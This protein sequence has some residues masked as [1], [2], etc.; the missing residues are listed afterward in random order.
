MEENERPSGLPENFT[1]VEALAASQK[2]AQATITRLSQELSQ[3]RGQAPQQTQQT[4]Q[5]TRQTK[6]Q[7]KKQI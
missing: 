6:K 1:S 5:P 3:L 4:Q 7:T 2:E